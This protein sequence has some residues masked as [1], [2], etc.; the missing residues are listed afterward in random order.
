MLIL[1]LEQAQNTTTYI[2]KKGSGEILSADYSVEEEYKK[3]LIG[4]ASCSQNKQLV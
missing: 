4:T 1:A 2:T 3:S